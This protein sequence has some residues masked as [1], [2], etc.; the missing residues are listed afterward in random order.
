MYQQSNYDDLNHSIDLKELHGIDGSVQY[1]SYGIQDVLTVPDSKIENL[2]NNLKFFSYRTEFHNGTENGC[3]RVF[4]KVEMNNLVK[5][6]VLEELFYISQNSYYLRVPSK[7]SY[8]SIQ[9]DLFHFDGS[10][11]NKL[12]T[13]TFKKEKGAFVVD[14]INEYIEGYLGVAVSCSD[15]FSSLSSKILNSDLKE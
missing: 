7:I 5:F 15:V 2:K 6:F 11:N 14:S 12:L 4:A 1:K 8:E 13:V 10:N 3:L 9:Y